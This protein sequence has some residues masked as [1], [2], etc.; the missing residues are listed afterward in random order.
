[1]AKKKLEGEPPAKKPKAELTP[2][3]YEA[4]LVELKERIKTAQLRAAIAV[5]RELISVYYWQVGADI[6]ERQ[7]V[8]C[9][10]NAVLDRLGED[11]QKTF[12][13][14]AGFSRTNLYRMGAFCLAYKDVSVIVPQDVGQIAEGGFSEVVVGIPCGDHNWLAEQVRDPSDRLYVGFALARR[15][16]PSGDRSID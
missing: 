9:S 10:G 15:L 16:A 12:P 1:M 2:R 5:N 13:G 6:V 8:Y 11:L 3:G 14:L 4:F 7:K